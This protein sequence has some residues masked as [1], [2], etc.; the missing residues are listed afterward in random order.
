[1]PYKALQSL[2]KEATCKELRCDKYDENCWIVTSLNLKKTLQKIWETSLNTLVISD[3]SQVK[4][5]E[6]RVKPRETSCDVVF[7]EKNKS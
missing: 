2:P 6:N 4:T 3:L 5:S 1:M 7:L